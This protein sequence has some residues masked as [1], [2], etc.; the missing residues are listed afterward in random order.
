MADL[1][2]L[3]FSYLAHS[4]VVDVSSKPNPLQGW[5]TSS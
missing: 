1:E 4:A 5:S 3:Q 2:I